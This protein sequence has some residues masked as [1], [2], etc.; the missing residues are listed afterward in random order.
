MGIRRRVAGMTWN[1]LLMRVDNSA[2]KGTSS[3][4]KFG[5]VVDRMN[6]KLGSKFWPRSREFAIS[7]WPSYVIRQQQTVFYLFE[8]HLETKL[9][10]V[11][12]IDGAS[13]FIT[14][15]VYSCSNG[16]C[17]CSQKWNRYLRR[18][19]WLEVFAWSTGATR[20]LVVATNYCKQRRITLVEK[21][22]LEHAK[23]AIN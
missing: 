21:A 7:P 22:L 20:C 9:Q 17:S 6:V 3:M 5:N 19:P 16:A 12:V 8:N 4:D 2:G 15:R 14:L 18:P 11:T 1:R 13:C 10:H 23:T